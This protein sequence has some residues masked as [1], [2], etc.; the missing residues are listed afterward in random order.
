MSPSFPG[1]RDDSQERLG[2]LLV[3][4]GFIDKEQLK[5]ALA[6]Q[7]HWGKRLGWVLVESGFLSE[8]RLVRG[9][10][11]QLNIDVCD[12]VNAPIHERVRGLLPRD[13]AVSMR[14]IPIAVKRGDSGDQLY[15]AT[16]DPLNKSMR[17]K[18]TDIAGMHV[19]WLLAGDSEIDQALSVHYGAHPPKFT[20]PESAVEAAPSSTSDAGAAP[21]K[22]QFA[23]TNS[24]IDTRDLPRAFAEVKPMVEPGGSGASEA[25]TQ[26]AQ[27]ETASSSGEDVASPDVLPIAPAGNWGDLVPTRSELEAEVQLGQAL[28]PA[29][30]VLAD[31]P[32]P[33]ERMDSLTPGPAMSADAEIFEG[34]ADVPLVVPSGPEEP[35]AVLAFSEVPTDLGDDDVSVEESPDDLSA[36]EPT[37]MLGS[38]DIQPLPEAEGARPEP[39][40]ES[41]TLEDIRPPAAPDG[42][43]PAEEAE[44]AAQA[45]AASSAE[46]DADSGA[47]ATGD[48]SADEHQDHEGISAATIELV[49]PAT[50]ELPPPDEAQAAEA[51]AGPGADEG[52]V[53]GTPAT[54]IAEE[55]SEDAVSESGEPPS[56]DAAD[57]ADAAGGDESS[58]AAAES[59]DPAAQ[60]EAEDESA[61]QVAEEAS[62]DDAAE[63]DEA[64]EPPSTEAVD[65]P[66]EAGD[67]ESSVA[68]GDS[69][70]AP[71]D[72]S[73]TVEAY[74]D[75]GSSEPMAAKEAG[76]GAQERT[77]SADEVAEPGDAE[78]SSADEVDLGTAAERGD[79]DASDTDVAAA[80]AGE[81]TPQPA[82]SSEAAVDEDAPGAEY[83]EDTHTEV[84]VSAEG[85]DV[86]DAEEGAGVDDQASNETSSP[87]PEDAGSPGGE[88]DRADEDAEPVAS[89][90]VTELVALSEVGEA[91][92]PD[93]TA[94]GGGAEQEAPQQETSE[95][96]GAD[97]SR[98]TLAAVPPA[99]SLGAAGGSVPPP[100][101]NFEA[102]EGSLQIDIDVDTSVR[103]SLDQSPAALAKLARAAL[104]QFVA[105][106]AVDDATRAWVMRL[107]AHILL[108]EGL[109]DGR[110]LDRA[111]DSVGPPDFGAPER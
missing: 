80:E 107:I 54:Q 83:A 66:A 53:E 56:T 106:Q 22:A 91:T 30:K 13:V 26:L 84:R 8:A 15:V 76:E 12:P 20:V 39:R 44:P 17:K 6:R 98:P 100:P 70:E 87:A 82:D 47:S 28:T 69:I 18:L 3:E 108:N 75:P 50:L 5:T 94:L 4:L 105:G 92:E 49:P 95:V 109:L 81:E 72:G 10:S 93:A 51:E 59:E 2:E 40:S 79:T 14:V 38:A 67:D 57:E 65:E 33:A 74:D 86:S 61:T 78:A 43:E 102:A 103:A 58:G 41:M 27:L 63:P 110:R 85:D 55:A 24:K 35:E 97:A 25:A 101:M 34:D 32:T 96:D 64:E 16:A 7:R 37:E 89:D 52:D 99:T 104:G 71:S 46:D 21:P 77:E 23:L 42:H 31:G 68:D 45:D 19:Q 1:H 36:S 90:P 9:L 48:G 111:I 88:D 29:D 11:R 73:D 62:E 60:V